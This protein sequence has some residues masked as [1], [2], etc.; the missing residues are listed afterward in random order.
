MSKDEFPECINSRG[1]INYARFKDSYG[2]EV[3]VQDSSAASEPHCW[4]FMEP[5]DPTVCVYN[6]GHIPAKEVFPDREF[7]SP[8][9]HLNRKQVKKLIKGLQLWLKETK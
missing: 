1:L 9:P 6:K 8:S 7:S 4:I 5:G 2:Y 3:R